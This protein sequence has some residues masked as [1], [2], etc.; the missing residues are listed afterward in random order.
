M[1][2]VRLERFAVQYHRQAAMVLLIAIEIDS[3]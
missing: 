2:R 1:L 3:C